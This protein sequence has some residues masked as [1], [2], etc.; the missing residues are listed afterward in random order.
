L[1]PLLGAGLASTLFA[2]AL[3]CSGQNSTLTGTLAGQVVME[4]FLSLRIKPWLRR[5]ITR[6]AAIIPAALVIGIAG[7]TKAMGL[8][9][10]SQVI[11]SFQLP[12]ALVPLVQFTNDKRRMGEFAN[13]WWVAA[14]AWL[15]AAVIIILNGLLIVL[16]L[17][18]NS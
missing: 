7:E 8:L 11:L 13:S 4:G 3:L 16:I 18:G 10:L 2:A 12:F 1:T 14:L 5:L 17:R 9:I 15:T 6:S